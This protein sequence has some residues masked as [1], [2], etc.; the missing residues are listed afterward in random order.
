MK[1]IN[2]LF[3]FAGDVID[4]WIYTMIISL[5]ILIILAF[6][7][8]RFFRSRRSLIVLLFISLLSGI[9]ASRYLS[10]YLAGLAV[11]TPTFIVFILALIIKSI[12]DKRKISR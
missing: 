9:L 12:K 5:V 6:I 8:V 4:A 1:A 7:L 11:A 2:D 10:S 3:D